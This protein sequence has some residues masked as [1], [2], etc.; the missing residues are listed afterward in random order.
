M[1]VV[2]HAFEQTRVQALQACHAEKRTGHPAVHKFGGSSVCSAKAIERVVD[3]ILDNCTADDYVVVS[4]MGDTTDRLFGLLNPSRQIGEK[5][6]D[7]S[8][9][10]L[11]QRNV[12]EQ[13]LP[14]EQATPPGAG[15]G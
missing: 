4:A 1:S 3:I 13:L 7:C 14:P 15:I 11:Y 12:I 9:V 2:D 10:Y 8:G 6:A 5:E